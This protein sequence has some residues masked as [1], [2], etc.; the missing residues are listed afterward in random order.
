MTGDDLPPRDAE[1][2][3]AG[4]GVDGEPPADDTPEGDGPQQA[5]TVPLGA[6]VAALAVAAVAVVVAVLSGG[7][8]DGGEDT[9]EVRLAAGRFAERF[10]TFDAADIDTWVADVLAVSTGGFAEE[11]ERARGEGILALIEE[12][13]MESAAQVRETFVGDVGGGEAEVMVE[14]SYTITGA[15]GPRPAD[16]Q[17]L[18]LNLVRV[19]GVWLVDNVTDIASGGGLAPAVP[20]PGEV[21]ASTDPPPG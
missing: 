11:F 3:A 9:T 1:P 19:D 6:F 12:L 10:L 2:S 20:V 16:Q 18:L 5:R 15:A 7:G 21:P 8:G 4:E 14:V 13:D 17:F